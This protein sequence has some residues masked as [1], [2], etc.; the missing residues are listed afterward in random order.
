LPEL[1]LLCAGA[2]LDRSA[3]HPHEA[4]LGIDPRHV[5]TRLSAGGFAHLFRRARVVADRHD[6]ALVPRDLPEFDWLRQQFG[7]PGDDALEAHAAWSHAIE[8]GS[9]LLTPSHVKIGLDHA[10]LTDPSDLALTPQEAQALADVAASSLAE[11]G[12]KLHSPSPGAWFLNG[13]R[14]LDLQAH[15]WRMAAGRNVDAYLPSG[16]DARLWRRMLSEVQML[17]HQHPVNL[18]REQRGAQP[19]NMLWLEGRATRLP[20]GAAVALWSRSMALRSLVQASGGITSEAAAILP[21][22]QEFSEL[23]ALALGHDGR[24]LLIE[25]SGWSQ[26]RRRNDGQQW[27]VDW[28]QFEAWLQDTAPVER[29]P[30]AYS[31]IRIILTGERRLLELVRERSTRWKPW[32]RL[33]PLALTF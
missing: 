27:L 4:G 19:V 29:L 21:S 5:R 3:Q 32:R 15:G 13:E 10:L 18:A 24:D 33:D 14:E 23:A 16:P 9:W 11:H 25:L 26:S 31:S 20:T 28:D 8:P 12:F 2:A 1:I 6:E 7:L 17:W 30:A 22:R